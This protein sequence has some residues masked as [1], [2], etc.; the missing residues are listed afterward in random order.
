MTDWIARLRAALAHNGFARFVGA[1]Q[2]AVSDAPLRAELLTAEQMEERG[3]ELATEHQ[4][5]APRRTDSLLLRRLSLNETVIHEA[6]AVLADAIREQRRITPGGEW[7][8]DNLYLVDEQIRK[9]RQHLPQNYS[10]ELPVLARGVAAGLPRV[11]DIALEAIAHGDGRVDQESLGR[12]VHAYQEHAPLSLGELWAIPI[13]LRL[14][15]IENLRRA[16]FRVRRERLHSNLADRWAAAMLDI[17]QRDPKSLILVVADMARAEPPMTSAFVA[18]IARRLQGTTLNLPMTWIEQRLGEVGLTTEQLVQTAHHEQAI[19]QVTISNSIGSLRLLDALDW[20]EFVENT[21]RVEQ[22]LGEDPAKVYKRMDFATRDVYRHAVEQLA[23]QTRRSET[24]VAREAV[25]QARAAASAVVAAADADLEAHVGFHLIGKGRA[26]L[27]RHCASGSRGLPFDSWRH[28]GMPFAT[29]LSAV[30]ALGIALAAPALG[31]VWTQTPSLWLRVPAGFCMIVALSYPVIWLINRCAV[32]ISL[33]QPLPRMDL[34]AGIPPEAR[35]LVVV[36]C[37]LG[38]VDEVNRLADN[39]ELRYVANRDA[40]LLFA[41][42]SDFA[43]AAEA[44]SAA[45]REIL[46]AASTAIEVLNRGYAKERGAVFFLLHRPRVWSESERCWMG[47]ERKRGKLTDLNALLLTGTSTGF[48]HIV[49]DVRNLRGMRYVITLDADTQLPRDAA[50]ML[51][52]TMQHPL[53]RPRFAANGRDVSAGYTILQPRIGN[54]LPPTGVSRYAALFGGDAGID[55]YTM[56]SSDLYQDLFAEGSFIGKGIYDVEAFEGAL[57]ERFP[58]NRILSHDLLEGCYAHAALTADIEL[59]EQYPQSYRVDAKRR[60][61]WIRGDWQIAAWLFRSVPIPA[62]RRERNPL[63]TLS[64]W[65]IFDNLRRSLL[66]PALYA[67]LL[68]GWFVLPAPVL[69]GALV[70][71]IALLPVLGEGLFALLRWP[72][73]GILRHLRD[74]LQAVGAPLARAVFMLACL[75]FEAW[76]NMTAIVRTGWRVHVSKRH[77]LQWVASSVV[78]QKAN[79]SGP[80]ATAWRE[81][82]IGP[83]STAIIA[84]ALWLWR[85]GVLILAA[86][87]L[88][89][90]LLA[91]PIAAWLSAVPGRDTQALDASQIA[92]VRAAARRTWAFFERFVSADDNWL[93]PDNFQEQP[94]AK[95]AHRT[96]ST[97]IGLGLLANLSAYDMGYISLRGLLARTRRTFDTLQKLDRYRGHLHNWYDTTTLQSL[98]PVYISTVDSGNF[99]ALVLTLRQGLFE[100][101]HTPLIGR[102]AFAGLADTFAVLRSLAGDADAPH[103]Q[104]FADALA[105]TRALPEILPVAATR[106][107]LRELSVRAQTLHDE[108]TAHGSTPVQE[109][110][111]KLLRQCAA[112]LADLEDFLEADWASDPADAGVASAEKDSPIPSLSALAQSASTPATKALAV[113]CVHEIEA[114]GTLCAD[115]ARVDYSFLY[116]STRDLFAIGYNVSDGRRDAGYYDLLA[117]EVR[118]GIYVAI[119]QGQVPQDSWFA[120]GRVLTTTDGG[121]VLLSWSGSMFEY[122]MPQ[123][124]MPTFPGTLL[125]QSARVAVARQIAYGQQNNVPWG[126]SESGFHL[127]DAGQNYHYRAFGVPGLGLQRGLAQ[128]LVIAPYASALALAVAPVAATENLRAIAAHGWLTP[129]G[130]Y[131][132]IDFT[133]ARIVHGEAQGV[134]REFM[135]HHQGMSL[136]ALAQAALTQTQQVP[137]MQRRFAADAELQATLLLLQERVPRGLVRQARDPQE[138]DVRSSEDSA[139]TP[140]RV[141]TRADRARPA[142]QLLSN[143]RYHVMLTETGAGYS[144]WQDL[145][146]TR[147][148][149]DPTR[150]PWGT[151]VYI[152]DCASDKVWCTGAQAQSAPVDLR[153]TLFTESTVELRLRMDQLE[154]R[155]QILVSPED[156]IELRRTRIG[157]RSRQPRTLEITSY[158]EV[159]LAP[160]VA[161]ALHPVFGNLFVQTELLAERDAILATRRP[162]LAHEMQPWLLHLAAVHGTECD[163]ISFETDRMRFLGRGNGVHNPAAMRRAGAL[164]GSAGAVLDPIVAIRQRIVVP[165]EGNV[166]VD[167]VTGVAT[168]RAGCIA[169]ADKYHDRYLADRA[170]DMA[171][172]HNRMVLGQLNI[173]EAEA[174]TYA[175]LAGAVLYADPARRASASVAASNRL[176]QSGLW[177]HAISGDLPIVLV[178]ISGAENG[179]DHIALIRQLVNAHTYCRLKGLV[180]DLVI[181]NEERGGYRQALHDQIVD[182]IAASTDASANERPGGIFV[183]AV[184]QINHEDRVLMQAVARV[185]LSDRA[186]SLAEQLIPRKSSGAEGAL[187]SEAVPKLAPTRRP[188]ASDAR[189]VTLPRLE[190]FNEFGGF[191]RNGREY[192]IVSSENQRT[193]LPWVNVIGNPQFGCVVSESGCGYTFFENAHEYRLTPWSNDPV[194]DACG[195]AFYLR[196]EESG[197]FWSPTPLPAAGRGRYLSRHGFGYS[198]FEHIESGIASELRIH[199]DVEAPVKFFVIRLRNDSGRARR[200]TVTGYIEWVLGDLPAKTAMHVVSELDASGALLARN[201]WDSDFAEYVGF[202]DVDHPQRTISSDRSEFIGRNGNLSQPAAMARASLSGRVGALMDPCAAIQIPFELADGESRDFIF[203][204]GAARNIDEASALIARFRH[205]GSART[206]FDAVSAQWNR[207]LGAVVVT[208]PDPALNALA[209][210]WLLY[211]T[212]A[213]RLWARSGFYQS[214]GAFGFRDQLQDAM[215]LVH[216]APSLLRAQIVLAAQHQFREGDVQHWWH[217][218]GGRGVRTQCSDDYLWLP[219]AV[220]RYVQATGDRAVLDEHS[221]YLEGRLLNAGEESYYDLP[222]RSNESADL[223]QHCVRALE[224]AITHGLSGSA[225]GLPRIGSCDWNDGM[226]NVGAQGQGESVWLG[227]FFYHVLMEFRALARVRGDDSYAA[228]CE[229][230][231]TELQANLQR[232]GWDGDW[233]RRA[234]FDDGTALGSAANTQCRIDS[235]AQSWAVLSGAGD[236]QHAARALDALDK[237]LVDGAA[238]LIRLLDPPFDR[239][240][241]ETGDGSADQSAANQ[242]GADQS[243]ATG[244]Q[245]YHDPGYIAGYVPGVR[246]NGGQY[247]HA[248]TWAVMAFAQA[249]RVERAW[250][251]FDLINPLRH[252]ETTAA[253]DVYKT[254]PYVVAADVYSNQAHVGRGGWT[255]YTGSAG[256]MYRL[257]IET[258]LGLTR[259]GARLRIAPRLPRAWPGV[260]ISYRHG[261]ATYAISVQRE[262]TRPSGT[263][264]LDGQVQPDNSIALVEAGEHRVEVTLASDLPQD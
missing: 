163:E 14:A 53:N 259:E 40:Q 81:M 137:P 189:Q 120:L 245:N 195:E 218:P 56:A 109:W 164:S 205:L 221:V 10:F 84:L 146:V 65:K 38:S 157:N 76:K 130:F 33:P 244:D 165:A 42:L 238:R 249:G 92:F 119:A 234:Y 239:P 90:W 132:A 83:A 153:E 7:L 12:F 37:L 52:A 103:C 106:T 108:L 184:E 79:A 63:S 190:L 34:R 166:I 46:D 220:C 59:Y 158:A 101:L 197:Q 252:A 186:G 185:V 200:L 143:G 39:L 208:T 246:E 207:L 122:L 201:T 48:S 15:L 66:S 173:S 67:L 17:A 179:V 169:L 152:R 148:R 62:G 88:L 19:D 57:G 72:A 43:D 210:G 96:S 77:L 23:R 250:E 68:F 162:R 177:A 142:V 2:D 261:A 75:P 129:L 44:Q 225:H 151:F 199:V 110:G 9:A 224:R 191:A 97:N 134:V 31:F 198:Q 13:M 156:D 237:Q 229:R 193:P 89:L 117:S 113:A 192:V 174:Q 150:D 87:W 147:W 217:P 206:S 74:S 94:V 168:S 262:A 222:L 140:L 149:E 188:D 160:G 242:S 154:V 24:D 111:G 6:C 139:P 123:L 86:P 258:L 99:V 78:E 36:P 51:V 124:V 45:D 18:E 194:S 60:A 1:P 254:E 241:E 95:I 181:W 128:D 176:S 235:I 170:I 204:L 215:A 32:L 3:G 80:Y 247:T 167:M 121:Q 159:V 114:L 141:F 219:L 27:R 70:L 209:N 256:W 255:W 49:G 50:R 41:L 260:E 251:L 145:S 233:Y 213:C 212:I 29:Y 125:E 91:P 5:R 127:T 61:R 93:P 253:V 64:R 136:L 107:A 248:A 104:A 105:G 26:A 264:L 131:E 112:A 171:Q 30:L 172:T 155:T 118:L 175:R 55:P 216:A 69:C 202:F 28:G 58:D 227:F 20:R 236:P 183:R 11:Y 135:A 8:L 263:I 144:H 21:S 230:V 231:A 73:G 214:G 71:A 240:A 228:R 35:T 133:P 4:L 257:I 85:P 196:D 25:T 203:R 180:F 161:D 98:Q 100:C 232:H 187:K 82:A 47:R 223:Y 138:V 102:Q 178:Q 126:I 243:G 116:D 182:A 54:L 16:A 211:Q 22:M 226:N 115:F